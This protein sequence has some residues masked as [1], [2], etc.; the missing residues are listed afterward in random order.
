MKIKTPYL[1]KPGAEFRLKDWS[2]SDTGSFKDEPGA[3]SD[4]AKHCQTL[5]N[6]QEVLFAETKHALRSCCRP[7][8]RAERTAP[9]GISSLE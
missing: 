9:S 6:L 2:T 8:T 5:G 7:W 1:V 3:Q 4:L